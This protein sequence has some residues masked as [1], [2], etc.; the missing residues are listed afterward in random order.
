MSKSP[1][2]FRRSWTRWRRW[3]RWRRSRGLAKRR[4]SAFQRFLLERTLQ[5]AARSIAGNPIVRNKTLRGPRGLRVFAPLVLIALLVIVGRRY[6][7]Q[8]LDVERSVRA[9]IIPQLEKEL[10]QKIEV[11]RVESDWLS[12]VRIYDIVIGRTRKSPLGALIQAKSATVYLD[13]I[14]LALRRLSPLQALRGI[15]L[16]GA[17]IWARRDARGR[18]NLL[19]L[20]KKRSGP[21]G[22]KWAGW[23][24]LRNGRLYAEDVSYHSARGKTLVVDARGLSA[25]VLLNGVG[26]TQLRGTLPQTFLGNESRPIRDIA[27]SGEVDSDAKWA[28]ANV[29]LPSVPLPLL[30]EWA[31]KRGEAT[32]KSG[33]LGA[34]L[35]LAHDASAKVSEQWLARGQ[36][37]LR[38]ASGFA[39][40]VKEPNT[41]QPVVFANLDSDLFFNNRATTIQT[42]RLNALNTNWKIA[43]TVAIPEPFLPARR[44]QKIR[45]ILDLNVATDSAD[46][47]RLMAMLPP[48]LARDLQMSGGRAKSVMRVRGDVDS[49]RIDGN[50][51]LPDVSVRSAKF[52]SARMATL[53]SD[54][55][56]RATM[57]NNQLTAANGRFNISAPGFVWTQAGASGITASAR[58]LQST[59]D[60]S[61]TPPTAGK[62]LSARAKGRF[63]VAG[64]TGRAARNGTAEV[65]TL[66][67][68]L[69]ASVN[70]SRSRLSTAFEAATLNLRASQFGNARADSLRGTLQA[71]LAGNA[72][73]LTTNFQSSALQLAAPRYGSGSA[74]SLRGTVRA[75]LVGTAARAIASVRSSG[76]AGEAPQFGRARGDGLDGAFWFAGPLNGSGRAGGSLALRDFSARENRYGTVRGSDLRLLTSTDDLALSRPL[77]AQWRGSTSFANLDARGIDLAKLSPQAA[78]QV[79]ELGTVS[80]RATFAAFSIADLQRARF[81]QR[82]FGQGLPAVRGELRL[83]NATIA[84]VKLGQASAN[85]ALDEGRLRIA[86]A[87]TQSDSGSLFADIDADLRAR[88]GNV[89]FSAPRV[90]LSASQ[91]NPY[92]RP[93]GLEASGNVVGRLSVRN[94]NRALNAFR[95]SFDVR[96]PRGQIRTLDFSRRAPE[97]GTRS[98]AA[99]GQT[100]DVRGA[101][102]QGS[103]LA[104]LGDNNDLRFN[105]QTLITAASARVASTFKGSSTALALPAWLSGSTVTNLEIAARGGVSKSGKTLTPNVRGEVRLG[106]VRLPVLPSARTEG[107]S[108]LVAA[109]GLN[110]TLDDIRLAFDSDAPQATVQNV[111]LANVPRFSARLGS[112]RIDGHFT[113]RKNGVVAGQ[114][115]AAGLN[116]ADLQRL[117]GTNFA[118]FAASPA[119]ALAVSRPSPSTSSPLPADFALKGIGFARINVAGTLQNLRADVQARLMNGSVRANKMTMPIDALRAEMSINYPSLNFAGEPE[120]VLWSRGARMAVRGDVTPRAKTYDLNLNATVTD[121]RLLYAGMVPQLGEALGQANAD[122]VA[123][124]QLKITG[125]PENPRVAGRASLKLARAF[126]LAIESAQ[127]SVAAE[128]NEGA[129]KVSLT[130]LSGSV[131]GSPFGGSASVDVAANTW[132]VQFNAASVPSHRLIRVADALPLPEESWI[133][134]Q[135]GERLGDLPL[136]G[137]VTADLSLSGT[138]KDADGRFAIK[139]SGGSASL[140]TAALRWRGREFG[141]VSA[142]LILED[143]VLQIAGLQLWGLDR[144]ASDELSA[145]SLTTVATPA[146][147]TA[148]SSDTAQSTLNGTA[149]AQTA[150]QSTLAPTARAS[151][152]RLTGAIPLSGAQEGLE[153]RLVSE[154][155]RVSTLLAIVDEAQRFMQERKRSFP[156]LDNAVKT[157]RSFPQGIEGRVALDARVRGSLQKPTVA[158]D[159]VVLRDASFP[160][161][162]GQQQLPMLDAAFDFD[163][164]ANQVT[165]R[166]AELLLNKAETEKVDV[167]EDDTILRIFEG[168]TIQ[169]GGVID[170]EGEL[171]HAN[172]LQI[173]AWVPALRS[174]DGRPL[175]GG[176]IAQ[177]EFKAA[178][179]SSSP[180]ITGSLVA[181]KLSYLNNSIDK[182]RVRR[183]VIGDGQFLIPPPEAGSDNGYLEVVKGEFRSS[184]AWGR[185]PW[186]W[187]EN[188]ELPGP[189][190]ESKMEI[191]FPLNTGNFGAIAGIA[192]PALTNV[193]ADN[194]SGDLNILGTLDKPL[195]SGGVSIKNG[196][197]RFDPAALPFDVGL[198]GL[199]GTV[200]FV[201]GNRLQIDGEDYLRGQ[202][203]SAEQVMAIA[204]GNPAADER[205]EKIATATTSTP[206]VKKKKTEQAN[207]GGNFALR[208]GVTFDLV[209]GSET[210][211]PDAISNPLGTLSRHF[212][213]LSFALDDAQLTAREISGV[214]D[215]ALAV[216]WKTRGTNAPQG[217]NVR[218]MMSAQSGA[219]AR[220]KQSAGYSFS[221]ASVDLPPNFGEGPTAISRA[222]FRQFRDLSGFETLGVT[223]KLAALKGLSGVEG[224]A[225][226]A[227]AR[228]QFAMVGFNFNARGI[229]RGVVDGALFFDN[230][231]ATAPAPNLRAPRPTIARRLAEVRAIS[232][233]SGAV[234]RIKY[235][236]AAPQTSSKPTSSEARVQTIQDQS[237]PEEIVP[238]EEVRPFRVSGEITVSQA[239]IVGT[240]PEGE[241]GAPL[242]LPDFPVMDVQAIIGREVQ[243]VTPNLRAEISGSADID[244]TPR[245]PLIVGTFATRNGQV[246]FPNANAR[247][248]RGEISLVLSRDPLT[249]LLRPNVNMDVS[250]RGQAG[251][252]QIELT[253]KGPLDLGTKNTQ[254]LQIEVTSNPPLSQSEAFAKLFGATEIG[255]SQGNQ[256]YAG[257]V[258]GVVSAP[259]FSGIERSL[260]RALGLSSITFEYRFN[261][262]LSIQ[263]G[264]SI[265][266]RVYI[267]YRRPFGQAQTL[268][269]AGGGPQGTGEVLRI[270]YRIKGNYNLV[271]QALREQT[272]G[273]GTSGSLNS[274][275]T[276]KQLTIERTFRF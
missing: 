21:Q 160:Y 99:P 245:N 111:V 34:R 243:L 52:G 122:G 3:S 260:E 51:A 276:R 239:Q 188:G 58:T 35:Q 159:R 197:F 235:L 67:G 84:N 238:F 83:A 201:E 148:Q 65:G 156:A 117:V 39:R 268:G 82:N 229:G 27:F 31:I 184:S 89:S 222:R 136:R 275:S 29:D 252:Y 257:A 208:G 32:L 70:G 104:R 76:F 212:Y 124:A 195:L 78:A 118:A 54:F 10:G 228:S 87:Q 178:G 247:I 274:Q 213:D 30:A 8:T 45:P 207:L 180:T 220:K 81:D 129:P 74:N 38:G 102:L 125:T 85:F 110:P 251:T 182:L 248:T 190:R 215:G 254:N 95:T 140:E 179:A 167:S 267:T 48:S 60:F 185:I 263:L 181:D 20:V 40:D 43:G 132:S 225:T 23:I 57:R 250:A 191:H 1:H 258:L 79:Q 240:P 253:M 233:E 157:I 256:A 6:A 145:A 204:T 234:D 200:R 62:P 90:Q 230:Q 176:E 13:P 59:L 46:T 264:K 147:G 115:L 211:T 98:V 15:E 255:S 224:L 96:L 221:Y 47:R 177:F 53:N 164:E 214:R 24:R 273:P 130:E 94:E 120:L 69:Q 126:G 141:T 66:S 50:L 231:R 152:V 217:Q 5:P 128:M 116:A 17:Q 134:N 143:D 209:S 113:M 42:L 138:L 91:I 56:V 92:L 246:R 121:F 262:P 144:G 75:T 193:A 14:G 137:E 73:Q 162:G 68:T 18:L 194:F 269:T 36:L 202:I 237:G 106:R 163:P 105:G 88:T 55:Q 119:K 16:D 28:I 150:D 107:Q 216:V 153:A 261:E 206:V 133:K 123:S 114:I 172:L 9:E 44:G 63:A 223:R 186:S 165:I 175:V 249:G 271:F 71:S 187:G 33:T 155:A 272:E 101:R 169:P 12:R 236:S 166:K 189:R 161:A 196:R 37:A 173:A 198:I 226:M 131:G 97:A 171:L 205:A 7:I 93:L 244:G 241:A 19:E 158:V 26:P 139:P 149:S 146:S 127:T 174:I 4:T 100:I 108:T 49:P 218:W 135:D 259:L 266:D 227:D 183:F 170:V 64:F 72:S 86:G 41:K 168:G 151:L 199:N 265:G 2:Q 61:T 80:G 22:P 232:N 142:D 210:G 109:N 77:Q 219:T 11:G 112:G 192:M 270:E 25:E 103:G 242:Q 154:D 203:A